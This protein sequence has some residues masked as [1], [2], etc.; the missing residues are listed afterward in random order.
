MIFYLN[1][2]ILNNQD[3]SKN[4]KTK[5]A[6][7]NLKRDKSLVKRSM[8]GLIR[9]KSPLN[10]NPKTSKFRQNTRITSKSKQMR[11]SVN[12]VSLNKGSFFNNE[13][14]S[15]NR[16]VLGLRT[17]KQNMRLPNIEEK[18]VRQ[19]QRT[20]DF[21]NLSKDSVNQMDLKTRIYSKQNELKKPKGISPVELAFQ[22]VNKMCKDELNLSNLKLTDKDLS[23]MS[24]KLKSMG[25]VKI[26]KLEKNKLTGKD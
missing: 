14:K 19:S 12:L 5:E 24:K 7:S 23:K 2:F 17:S 11:L 16:S 21:W 6:E 20:N 8:R 26:I 3:Q 22:D 4:K 18:S 1:L 9:S 10:S 25:R 13:N 15:T